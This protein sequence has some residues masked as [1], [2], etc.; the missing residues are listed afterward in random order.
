M[1]SLNNVS[2]SFSGDELFE[3]ISFIVNTRDR[4][5]LVG[6]NGAGKTSLLRIITGEL[7]PL[8]GSVSMPSG[9]TVGYLPQDL[10]TYSSKTVFDEAIDAFAGL[11]A[12]SDRIHELNTELE[13]CAD[14]DLIQKKLTELTLLQDRLS[15]NDFSQM[16]ANTEKVLLGLGFKKDEF[17][18]PMSSFSGGWQ[19]RVHL[20]KL[21][22]KRPDVLLLDEPTNHLDIHAIQWLED[23]LYQY[24]G[25]VIL[26]S[27]DR[28]FLDKVTGRTVEILLGKIYD[29]KTSYSE[30]VTLREERRAQQAAAME[31]QQKQIAQI[32]KFI[33]RFRY[34]ASKARQVQS[35]IKLLEKTDI[36]SVDES[37]NSGMHFSFPRA[38]AS[39]KVVIE[40]EKLSKSFG[41][42]NVFSDVNLAV[43]R[44]EK[45]AFVGRNGE[46]KTTLARIIT[47]Q[48][49]Y[50]GKFVTGYNVG[51]GYYAQNHAELL[52]TEKT[53]FSTVDDLATGDMRPRVRA[54]LG[55][56]LFSGD[57]IEKKVKVLSGGEKSRLALVT[58][59]LKPVNLLVLDEP[60]NHLDML[61]KDI[62]KN[63]L[64]RYDGTLIIVSHDRDFLQGLTGKVVEFR[65]NRVKEYLG[66]IYD[67]LDARKMS[68]LEELNRAAKP[69]S[70]SKASAVSE[71]ALLR[72][73]KKEYEK[74]RRRLLNRIRSCEDAISQLENNIA[75]DEKKLHSPD[76]YS[77]EIFS[78]GIFEHYSKLKDQLKIQ[79]EEW[80]RLHAELEKISES[81]EGGKTQDE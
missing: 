73:K 56:F 79:M 21:L 22:L 5:G 19:M 35:K 62:L 15:L 77:E 16:E 23:F 57:A 39:G 25:A 17:T 60:T 40:M 46:G 43:L 52:D 34:K 59:L 54:L 61:S 80:E 38:P 50:E 28:A 70:A 67:Y 47:G 29:Y 26:V 55:S 53:V 7:E 81:F 44:G 58:L 8:K 4:I 36:L 13:H 1:L 37:D 3:D 32:E 71:T 49:D 2:V 12:M 45:V 20:A 31:N 41:L 64:L 69:G 6:R 66:D 14:P 65:N 72:E 10:D 75:S 27:H 33:E 48:L 9:W 51:I 30:Y 11:L 68:D 24:P 18:R 76:Q 42:K 78:G 74:M 63:A